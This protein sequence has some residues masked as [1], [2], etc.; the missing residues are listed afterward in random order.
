M[1]ERD[2][3]D[4]VAQGSPEAF[5]YGAESLQRDLNGEGASEMGEAG[6]DAPSEEEQRS[7]LV[8]EQPKLATALYLQHLHTL[9]SPHPHF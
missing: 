6:D 4:N 9:L 8:G 3:A 2:H 1:R 7:L 5:L